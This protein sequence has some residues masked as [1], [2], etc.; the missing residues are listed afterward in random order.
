S[1]S[2]RLVHHV[3][4]CSDLNN[5]DRYSVSLASENILSVTPKPCQGS[6]TI[7]VKAWITRHLGIEINP[8]ELQSA[9][10]PSTVQQ[11]V[12]EIYV[13]YLASFLRI[14][15]CPRRDS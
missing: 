1:L 3:H 5:R 9:N 12:T 14:N 11:I 4:A 2:R 13:R 7:H 8:V 6:A 15:I 10:S